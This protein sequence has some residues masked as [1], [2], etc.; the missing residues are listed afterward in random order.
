MVKGLWEQFGMAELQL[1]KLLKLSSRG[2]ES[3]NS[4]DTGGTPPPPVHPPPVSIPP[5]GGTV[6]G[7]FQK[8]MQQCHI[9][10]DC[11]IVRACC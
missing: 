7:W 9:A 8:K 5:R 10:Q 3:L 1:L 11:I 2:S 6:T 4:G